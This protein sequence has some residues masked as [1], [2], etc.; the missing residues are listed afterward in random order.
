M[1][2]SPEEVRHI[3]NLA[4]IGLTE[5]ELDRLRSELGDILAH[6]NQLNELDTESIPPTAQVIALRDVLAEDEPRPSYPVD[7]MLAN[8]PE[9]EGNYFKT[10]AVLGYET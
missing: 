8:A 4:R 6:V 7:A 5:A 1:E 3:A 10:K 9:R 2:L